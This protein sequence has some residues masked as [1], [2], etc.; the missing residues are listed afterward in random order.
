[1]GSIPFGMDAL[2][3]CLLSITPVELK[4]MGLLA[5]QPHLITGTARLPRETLVEAVTELVAYTGRCT[6]AARHLANLT[7]IPLLTASV[8][9]FGA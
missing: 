1:M 8:L 5:Q 3:D 4:G 9:E 7:P 6:A 2:R